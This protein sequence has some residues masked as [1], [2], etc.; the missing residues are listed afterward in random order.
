M[1]K[2]KILMIDP[3]GSMLGLNTG[4]AYCTSELLN[5]GFA[6]SVL[7][8]N[9]FRDGDAR[10]RIK[11]AIF[12]A[13]SDLIGISVHCLS[14]YTT[15]ECIDTIRDFWSGPIVVGGAEAA[16]QA[17]QFLEDNP[18]VDIVVLGEGE[19]AIR[20]LVECIERDQPISSASGIVYRQDGCIKRSPPRM[21]EKDLNSVAFP[22]YD[23]FGVKHIDD[24][25]LMTSR[26]CPM[27]CSFC[28]SYTGKTWRARRPANCIEEI[29]QAREKYSID[30]FRISDPFFNARTDRVEEFCELYLAEGINLPWRIM[31]F[32]ADKAPISMLKKMKQAGCIRVCLGVETLDPYVFEQIDKG[33]SIETIKE[34]IKKLQQCGIEIGAFMIIGL[35]GDTYE[36]SLRSFE[37]LQ[38]LR[39]DSLQYSM[40]VPYLG[41][42]LYDWARKEANVFGDY[43]KTSSRNDFTDVVF[44]TKDFK[45]NDRI[46]AYKAISIKAKRYPINRYDP[47]IKR[48]VEK[49][50]LV[51]QYDSMHLPSHIFYLL[52]NTTQRLFPKK[53][54]INIGENVEFSKV[55]DG[56]WALKL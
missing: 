17:E 20:E 4:I 44:D 8:M 22:N 42:K 52:K 51:F 53:D 34:G 35:P 36:K 26:G 50:K 40:A 11:N 25:V 24:Y 2:S 41:S 23:V 15:Q 14:Y 27:N 45:K 30:S 55:P 19:R 47:L 18:K 9:N 46:K 49:F 1:K 56:T 48:N 6:V 38:R 33:E 29:K 3:E 28:F 21:F 10:E 12:F 54:A 31:G 37:Q 16:I 43:K 7:D 32:R 39:L 13:E 5:N